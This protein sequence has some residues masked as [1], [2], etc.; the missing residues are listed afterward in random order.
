MFTWAANQKDWTAELPLMLTGIIDTMQESTL[1]LP[2]ELMTARPV[3]LPLHLFQPGDS[4]LITAYST[5]QH[6]NKLC[7]K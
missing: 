6:H 4:S 3:M 5:H 2:T 7:L 1:V